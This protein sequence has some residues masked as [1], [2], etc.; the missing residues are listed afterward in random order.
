MLQESPGLKFM[1][2][3]F[4]LISEQSEGSWALEAARVW[5]GKLG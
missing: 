2:K 3:P 4:G 1:Y 5:M